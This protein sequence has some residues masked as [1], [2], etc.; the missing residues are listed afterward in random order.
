MKAVKSST[1]NKSDVIELKSMDSEYLANA[2][3]CKWVEVVRPKLLYKLLGQKPIS[4][5]GD[6][7]IVMIVDEEGWLKE[8]LVINGVASFLY[9]EPD[10]VG[11]VLFVAEE[12]TENGI[13]IAELTESEL[14]ALLDPL[15]I[16]YVCTA[17]EQIFE[18]MEGGYNEKNKNRM[19]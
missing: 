8:S 17:W 5:Y 7:N 19:V 6:R 11:D 1:D 4:R 3:G 16:Y 2:I 15:Y 12:L 18:S 13:D 10:I 9:G 14:I